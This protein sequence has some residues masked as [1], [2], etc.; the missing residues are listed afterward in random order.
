MNL[1][2]RPDEQRWASMSLM[3]QMANIGS[4]VGRTSKWMAKGNQQMAFGAFVRGIDLIDMT[5]KCGRLGMPSRDALLKELCRCRDIFA[6]AFLDGN[7]E[8]M[9]SLDR[10]FGHFALAVRG[11]NK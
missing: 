3:Q 9:E 8:A 7:L 2:A 10:Y 5:I 11:N 1:P 4:E 6:S